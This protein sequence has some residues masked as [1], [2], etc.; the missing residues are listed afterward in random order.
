MDD[1]FKALKEKV[2]T[3]NSISSETFSKNE[4]EMKTLSDKQKLIEFTTN[5][6]CLHEILKEVLLAKIKVHWTVT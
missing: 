4:G 1:T 2:T 5:R 3:K 6:T